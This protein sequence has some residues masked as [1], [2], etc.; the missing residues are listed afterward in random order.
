M[1]ILYEHLVPKVNRSEQQHLIANNVINSNPFV[2]SSDCSHKV[3]F[4]NKNIN[5]IIIILPIFLPLAMAQA[6]VLLVGSN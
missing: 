3:W 6:V 2:N 4:D 1:H 5:F